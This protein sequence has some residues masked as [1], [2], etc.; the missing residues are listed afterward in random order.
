[1]LSL[2]VRLKVWD[3]AANSA[4]ILGFLLT[5]CALTSP[6][7]AGTVMVFNVKD[8][9]FNALGNGMADVG[10]T[11]FRGRVDYAAAL[12]SNSAGLI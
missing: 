7:L 9:P 12:R 11:R 4:P 5:V 2:A 3:W 6:A 8:P 10:L 1:M